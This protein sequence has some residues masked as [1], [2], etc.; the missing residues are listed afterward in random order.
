[1]QKTLKMTETLVY[2]YSAESTQ[3]ELANEYQHGL[4]VLHKSLRPCLL[5]ESSLSIGGVKMI[6]SLI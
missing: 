6:Q 5:D 4:D 1:M 3:K 2:G